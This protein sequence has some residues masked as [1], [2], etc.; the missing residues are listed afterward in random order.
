M[1][2]FF[3]AGWSGDGPE[4]AAGRPRCWAR[5]APR[6]HLD[7][8]RGCGAAVNAQGALETNRGQSRQGPRAQELGA[9]VDAG[10]ED[11]SGGVSRARMTATG[12]GSRRGDQMGSDPV[13]GALL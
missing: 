13:A 3:S 11:D 9:A 2:L 5:P 6:S 8:A 10:E 1:K 7:R 12:R 4:A